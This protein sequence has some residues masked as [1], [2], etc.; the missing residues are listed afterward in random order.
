MGKLKKVKISNYFLV[1]PMIIIGVLAGILGGAIWNN[2]FSEAGYLLPNF[3][4]IDF[5]GRGL[6]GSTLTIRNPNKVIIEQETKIQE[7]L[8][9]VDKSIVGIFPKKN[10]KDDSV[11]SSGNYYV[12][13]QEAA[14]GLIITSDGWIMANMSGIE[15]GTNISGDYVVITSDQEIYE[16]DEVAVDKLTNLHF[17]HI[18]AGN[19]PIRGFAGSEEIV[20]GKEILVAGWKEGGYFG[21]VVS[22]NHSSLIEFSD[23]NPVE[24][25]LS[26]NLSDLKESF[27]FDL[28]GNLAGI[29]NASGQADH[30][31][32]FL[33]AIESLISSSEV[34]RLSLGIYFI[35]LENTAGFKHERGAIISK[36][37]NGIAIVAGSP[38]EKAGLKEGDVITAI[39]GI[40]LDENNKL[41][42]ILSQYQSGDKLYFDYWRGIEKREAEVVLE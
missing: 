25:S 37:A 9:A 35:D 2:Y 19:L 23:Y 3:G 32:N 4:S 40:T 26:D 31:D 12:L 13:G 5:S 29:I 10:I 34:K 27:V 28:N 39:E 38:A 7:T 15:K 24:I 8:A 21:Y 22:L 33:P 17:L 1:V 11:F 14:Q 41:D 20:P 42:N 6:S 30:L 36:N 18:N 16:I